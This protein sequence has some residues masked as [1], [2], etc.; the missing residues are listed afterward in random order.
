MATYTING[1]DLATLG[2]IVTSDSV[3]NV[4]AAQ[5]SSSLAVPGLHGALVAQPVEF[6]DEGKLVLQMFMDGG[7]NKAVHDGKLDG[8]LAL[9]TGPLDVRKTMMDGSVRQ[10]L[11]YKRANIDPDHRPGGW[12]RLTAAL[13]V[14]GVFWRDTAA[15]T[16]SQTQPVSGTSYVMANLAGSTAPIGDAKVLWTGPVTNPTAADPYSGSTVMWQGTVAAGAQVRVEAG[17]MTAVSG[18]G[19]G[20]SGA[21]TD[22]SGSL[23]PS[24]PGSAF[25][26]L[27]FTPEIVAAD[28]T[29]RRVRVTVTG[30]GITSATN[31]QVSARR[32][33][34]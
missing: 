27:D 15:S 2:V 1:V 11:C 32:A 26:L 18:T 28:P 17:T 3:V 14:P 19:I 30:T 34:F 10:M 20:L 9:L 13:D 23:V 16:F 21:G 22:V 8:L 33:F 6:Y 29:N 4:S 7:G 31:V 25:R 5:G 12:T 24:G